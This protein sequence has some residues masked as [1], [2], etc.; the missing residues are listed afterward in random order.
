MVA[1]PLNLDL[2]VAYAFEG[3]K[4]K[5]QAALMSWSLKGILGEVIESCK[6]MPVRGGHKSQG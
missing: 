1:R 6:I 3:R 2:A 5:I 4:M